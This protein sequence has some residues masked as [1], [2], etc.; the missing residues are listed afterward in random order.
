MRRNLFPCMD[1]QEG[2][3]MEE[4]AYHIVYQE[5]DDPVK[6]RR[7][8]ANMP[9]FF[10]AVLINSY[11]GALRSTKTGCLSERNGGKTYGHP[12]KDATLPSLFRKHSLPMPNRALDVVT[13]GQ[14]TAA[15]EAGLL[16]KNSDPTATHRI[17]YQPS[18]N[19]AALCDTLFRALIVRFTGRLG[20]F[21]LYSLR[22]EKQ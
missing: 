10:S 11:C 22:K 1:E 3:N 4:E 12:L 7:M 9:D 13:V 5:E 15:Y 19:H 16:Q 6:S 2:E 17:Q 18:Q 14:R 20:R 21:R 8:A